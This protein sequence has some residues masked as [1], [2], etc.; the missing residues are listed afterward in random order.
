MT[1]FSRG[2][3]LGELLGMVSVGGRAPVSRPLGSLRWYP[4][5][6]YAPTRRRSFTDG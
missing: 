6:A 3:I 1:G 5:L 2:P 4:E